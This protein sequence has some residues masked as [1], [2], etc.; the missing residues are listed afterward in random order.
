L[1]GARKGEKKRRRSWRKGKVSVDAGAAR[2]GS[3]QTNFVSKRLS[4]EAADLGPYSVVNAGI[5]GNRVLND[6]IGPAG[7]SRFGRDALGQTGVSSVLL[8]LGINDIGFSGFV[9]EQEVSADQITTGLSSMVEAM[10]VSRRGYRLFQLR[11]SFNRVTGRKALHVVSAWIAEN[12]L[13]LGQMATEEKS[14]EIAAISQ[15]L[16]MLDIRGAT[17]TVDAMGCQ[18]AIAEK[19]QLHGCLDVGFREDARLP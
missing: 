11:H 8:L 9:P 15:L 19:N 3:Q 5:S 2:R 7:L 18:R 14:N 1:P 16:E 13:T 12:R 10:L 6:V 17:V 4:G